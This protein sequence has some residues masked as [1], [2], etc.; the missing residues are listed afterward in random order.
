MRELQTL[1]VL[2]WI[3]DARQRAG[4]HGQTPVFVDGSDDIGMGDATNLAS[5]RLF[6]GILRQEIHLTT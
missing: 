4:H 2:L 3:T 1:A 6:T 5:C